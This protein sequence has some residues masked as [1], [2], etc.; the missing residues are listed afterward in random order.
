TVGFTKTLQLEAEVY[1]WPIDF[2]LVSPG[3]VESQIMNVGKDYGFPEELQKIVAS[4]ASCAKEIIQG[5]K[6]NK[7]EI[8]P[9][10]NGKA[11]MQMNK[12]LPGTLKL[13]G[14]QAFK[15]VKK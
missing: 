7:L 13:L 2:I 1:A 9:T 11:V 8:T 12:F 4:P 10:L 3:F 15:K 6:K 14:K 5:I